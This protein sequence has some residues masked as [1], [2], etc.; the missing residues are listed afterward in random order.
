M[1][2]G[3]WTHPTFVFLLV[4]LVLSDVAKLETLAPYEAIFGS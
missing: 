4:R 2:V 3:A 1:L